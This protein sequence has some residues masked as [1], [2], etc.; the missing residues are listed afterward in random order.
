MSVYEKFIY[1][2][3]LN[4]YICDRLEIRRVA[5]DGVVEEIDIA[6]Q[7]LDCGVTSSWILVCRNNI[8]Y[9]EIIDNNRIYDS[10]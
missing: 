9:I 2:H 3:I 6:S 7:A 5:R 1:E 10:Y 4:L 8:I